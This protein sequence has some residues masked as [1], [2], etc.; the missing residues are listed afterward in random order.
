[1]H[2]QLMHDKNRANHCTATHRYSMADLSQPWSDR[3]DDD[4][5][6]GHSM[7]CHPWC[8]HQEEEEDDTVWTVWHLD[9]ADRD[10]DQRRSSILMNADRSLAPTHNVIIAKQQERIKLMN[11]W[12]AHWW[13]NAYFVNVSLVLSVVQMWLILLWTMND[14]GECVDWTN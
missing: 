10:E 14:N 6:N 9:D 2:V 7:L 12:S 1:M 8:I 5:E 11:R 4:W 13:M 3:L